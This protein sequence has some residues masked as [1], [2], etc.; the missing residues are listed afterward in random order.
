MKKLSIVLLI[1]MLFSSCSAEKTENA[2]LIIK[3]QSFFSDFHTKSDKVYIDCELTVNNATEK[4]QIVQFVADMTDDVKIGL[5][6]NAKVTAYAE[7][8]Y[9][10]KFTLVKGL[11]RIRV[12]FIGDYAGV[13][14]KSSRNLP[15]IEIIQC[16]SNKGA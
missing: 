6:K 12:T 2:I 8:Y 14:Q 13:K 5:L 9:T 4:Q 1:I 15:K 10:S 7:D 11:Q 3:D 16:N